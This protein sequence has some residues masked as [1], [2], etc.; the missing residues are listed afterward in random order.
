MRNV[1]IKSLF[2]VL[3]L[4]SCSKDDATKGVE[5]KSVDFTDLP[6]WKLDAQ[7]E[8][9]DAFLRSCDA[10]KDYQKPFLGNA[11][12]KIDT[13]SFL[14]ICHKAKDNPQQNFRDFVEQ[15]FEPF[16]VTYNGS[17]IGKFT[18]YYEPIIKVSQTQNDEYKHPI[19]ARPLDLVEFNPKDF[20]DNLPSKR[21]LGRIEGQKLI[22]YY[23]REDI[24]NGKGNIPVLLWANNPVDVYIMHIQGPAVAQ[25]EDGSRIRISF[26][27]TNG[28]SFQGI[29]TILLKNKAITPAQASMGEIKKWLQNNPKLAEKYM[30]QNQRYVF[31]QLIGATGPLGAMGEPLSAGRS[32]AID[33]EFIPLGALIWLDTKLPNG[34]PLQRLVN[35]QDVGGAIKGAIRADYYWGSGGDEVLEL[36]GK[37][38]SS[39]RYYIFMPKKGE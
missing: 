35:A 18:A 22:P 2:L 24:A 30:N 1:L 32:I 21:L 10:L 8:A 15:N 19:H 20:D 38:N 25:F 33:K 27:D 31:H 39:G 3:V 13:Q 6:A 34:S 12:I 26:A 17:D 5:L 29:G 28:L 7:D 11:K 36:A 14:Q 23:T 16:L 37:M 4:A 9:R